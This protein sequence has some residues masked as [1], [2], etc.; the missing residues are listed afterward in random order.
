M[1]AFSVIAGSIA[2]LA[3]LIYAGF[4]AA[5][6]FYVPRFPDEIH[7]ATTSDGWRIALFRYRPAANGQPVAADPVLLVPGIGANHYNF[8][9]T[10]ETSL[11]RTLSVESIFLTVGEPFLLADIDAMALACAEAAPTTILTNGALFGGKRR[12]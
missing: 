10:D 3:L 7:F 4:L 1:L 8:D 2:L 12:E 6:Y 9:L 11:A 5:R